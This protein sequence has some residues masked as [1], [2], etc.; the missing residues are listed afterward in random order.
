[1]DGVFMLADT[2]GYPLALIL[3]CL[4]A[5]NCIVAWP[6]YFADA[7]SSGWKQETADK[8]AQEAIREVYGAHY[9]DGWLKSKEAFYGRSNSRE[10]S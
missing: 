4:K 1:M 3:E 7:R 5:Q 9:L 6:A 2:E 10:D 8:R